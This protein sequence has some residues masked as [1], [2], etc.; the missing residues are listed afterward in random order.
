MIVERN[1]QVLATDALQRSLQFLDWIEDNTMT[2]TASRLATVQRAI[3]DLEAQLNPSQVDREKSL[4]AKIDA[5]TRELAAVQSGEFDVLEGPQA[6]E[7][8]REVYQLA[9]SLQADFRR[10]EDSYREA[11]RSLRQRIISERQNRGQVVDGLL[12]SHDA[13][14]NTNEGQVFE[15]FTRNL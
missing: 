14:I 2:S 1:G 3:E 6:V 9:I 4:M 7:G 15:S 10:V 12:S 13:L 8:I 11:D 5:L